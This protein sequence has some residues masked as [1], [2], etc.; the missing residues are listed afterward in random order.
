M[1]KVSKSIAKAADHGPVLDRAGEIE[2]YAVNFVEFRQDID[3]TPLLKGCPDDRCQC[4]HWGY[5]MKGKLTFTFADHVEHFEAGDG[6]YVPPGHT[7]AFAAGTE[8]LMFSPADKIAA[9][10]EAIERNLA[11]LQSA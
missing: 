2:G 11:E 5:V 1:P 3:G 4:P 10:N 6:F 7:P 8:C 9:V